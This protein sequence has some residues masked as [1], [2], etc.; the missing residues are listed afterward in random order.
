MVGIAVDAHAD[1]VADGVVGHPLAPCDPNGRG[2]FALALSREAD[3]YLV[4]EP[5]ANLD[6][7]ARAIAMNLLIERTRGKSL[8]VIM[9]GF[10]EH[11]A[12]F[13]RVVDMIDLTGA[14]RRVVA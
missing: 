13:D 7:G 6:P 4:D 3:L 11:H 10:E 8:I 14:A 9:H 2:A 1:S 12:L 5:L